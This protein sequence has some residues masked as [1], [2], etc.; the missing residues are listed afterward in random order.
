MPPTLVFTDKF[1]GL[2][3]IS[4][5]DLN[6]DRDMLSLLPITVLVMLSKDPANPST[7]VAA[8]NATLS[9]TNWTYPVIQAMLT[10]ALR[11]AKDFKWSLK[12]V[13]P[14]ISGFGV[15][16]SDDVNVTVV[17][18]HPVIDSFSSTD[19]SFLGSNITVFCKPNAP[20]TSFMEP[21][22]T[23]SDDGKCVFI[24][25]AAAL[26]TFSTTAQFVSLSASQ[27]QLRCGT[28]YGDNKLLG[29]GPPYSKWKVRVVFPDGR[30][31]AESASLLSV[32]CPVGMYIELNA[33]ASCDAPPCCLSCPAPMSK[34]VTLDSI[35]VQS[36]MCQQGY[37][38][39]GGLS[40]VACPKSAKYGFV[41]ATVG[42]KVPIVKPGFYI[43]YSFLSTCS[44]ESCIAVTKCPNERAC[45]G[46]GEKIC[47]DSY[48][49]CYSNISAGCTECCPRYYSDNFECKRCP[50]SRL[51]IMLCLAILL[52]VVFAILSSSLSF[53]PFVA[54][55]KGTKLILSGLQSFTCIRL[56]AGL[57]SNNGVLSGVNWPDI[58]L[59][60]FEF[61]NTFT[62][63]LDSLRPQ[64]TVDISPLDKLILVTVGPCL[65]VSFILIIAFSLS[66]WK[67]RKI[68]VIL[69]D[70][71]LLPEQSSGRGLF[72]SVAY[73]F[74]VSTLCLKYSRKNQVTHGALWPA[75]DPNLIE[76]SDLSVISSR[77]RRSSAFI[78]H[79]DDPLSKADQL[80]KL[81]QAWRK[82]IRD[83]EMAG[84]SSFMKSSVSTSRLLISSAFSIFIFTFQ[85]VLE[86]MLSTWDCKVIENRR[87]LRS[88]PNVE[89]SGRGVHASMITVSSLGLVVYTC[90]VPV[91]VV[92]VVR[93][94]WAR[95]IY[96]YSYIAYDQLFGF[97]TSQ[98][99]VA[100]MSW[101]AV[102]CVRKLFVVAIPMVIS[103]SPITQ[104]LSNIILFLVYAMLV[105]ALKPM[106]SAYLNRIEVLNSFNVIVASFAA[107]LF[108][109]QY[110]NKYILQGESRDVV[111]IGLVT[112][113]C[114]TFLVSMRMISIEFSKL[115]ALHCNPFLS[116]WLRLIAAK[117]GASIVVDAY[118]P[119]SL[120]F[121][122]R[123]SSEEI[124]RAV[125]AG[126]D[127]KQKALSRAREAWPASTVL[128][129][130]VRH[131]VLAW[132]R[133]KLKIQHRRYSSKYEVD[134]GAAKQAMAEPDYEFFMWMHKLLQRTR[135]WE[136]HEK[137]YRNTAFWQL[138]KMFTVNYGKSDPPIAVCDSLLRT[139]RA[140]DAVLADGHQKLLLALLLHGEAMEINPSL[141]NGSCQEYQRQMSA[142]IECFKQQLFKNVR[143]SEMFRHTTEGDLRFM[144]CQPLRQKLYGARESEKM[145]VLQRIATTTL[146]EYRKLCQAHADQMSQTSAKRR[147]EP[148]AMLLTNEL[149][150][151]RQVSPNLPEPAGSK[152]AVGELNDCESNDRRDPSSYH[153]TSAARAALGTKSLLSGHTLVPYSGI[154]LSEREGDR[155]ID[156]D[157]PHPLHSELQGAD[158]RQQPSSGF[159]SAANSNADGVELEE[160]VVDNR[161]FSGALSP[162][163][164]ARRNFASAAVNA[165]QGVGAAP[166]QAAPAVE[167]AQI[168]K[169]FHSLNPTCSNESEAG[170]ND[171]VGAAQ[172]PSPYSCSP[173]IRSPAAGRRHGPQPSMQHSPPSAVPSAASS[174]AAARS[175]DLGRVDDDAS[176]LAQQ[177]IL[178]AELQEILA[179]VVR[180][181]PKA[182]TQADGH[183]SSKARERE[184]GSADVARSASS[185]PLRWVPSKFPLQKV[186]SL[187]DNSAP[188]ASISNMD[189]MGESN[190]VRAELA[191]AQ[192]LMTS[193]LGSSAAFVQFTSQQLEQRI[194]QRQQPI[195]ADHAAPSQP[196]A[197]KVSPLGSL[198]VKSTHLNQGAHQQHNVLVAKDNTEAEGTASI[199]R[200]PPLTPSPPPN[201]Q[202]PPLTPSP[203]PLP[204]PPKTEM[205]A[206]VTTTKKPSTRSTCN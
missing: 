23:A 137:T 39:S 66:L 121:I 198:S 41:C 199:S 57:S 120:L 80:V 126:E 89:C 164:N 94:R 49:E 177:Q 188:P 108:T 181:K 200:S 48:N 163:P 58:M 86:A 112:F 54:V 8:A 101:E 172:H 148:A 13:H 52:L 117:A 122:N 170:P 168:L 184:V 202:P 139:S 96:A 204:S 135:S 62:F 143:A 151:H 171:T 179:Q 43:D 29:L 201:P 3:G 93:S 183:G 132:T 90:V 180:P 116:K 136:P 88:R 36:C 34:S 165:A 127:I 138:P 156:A 131:F 192:K 26:K 7:Q 144:S 98:Y 119:I 16:V 159:Q 134:D 61:M 196:S 189:F 21:I 100:Q 17:D 51:V 174:P 147:Q 141:D 27:I 103:S 59:S 44:E 50:E 60:T 185:S 146:P 104:S 194:Q 67:I 72:A 69:R 128:N 158:K 14:A 2:G 154:S 197:G 95:E 206:H 28:V 142:M 20:A 73:C 111:G 173:D 195:V 70:A 77:R 87:F 75:L 46:G 84:V 71:N 33:S 64:C 109:A 91:C 176:R 65:I 167:F 118:L 53:P 25:T 178:M 107:I 40:C 38:G 175:A 110:E 157:Q 162:N 152:S 182:S 161:D 82:A 81:P 35:G 1:V 193:A 9:G 6:G 5:R 68:C 76:R 24:P 130:L 55:A 56:M 149:F 160:V 10:G 92:L 4:V 37:Y 15:I 166:R 32:R 78:A 145:K 113:I 12:L 63:S 99:T 45:P 114:F 11:P 79:A 190:P 129:S 123:T 105:T 187:T 115:Y 140:I 85:G 191:V 205:K 31:S 203:P 125:E 83:F 133:V 30:E 74:L 186:G 47:L 106:I 169:S 18:V 155:C 22:F 42:L 19:V 102:N 97:I 124:Q 153:D 150:S